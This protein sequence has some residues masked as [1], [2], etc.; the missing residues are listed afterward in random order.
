MENHDKIYEQIKNASKKTEEMD[1]PAMDKVWSRVE[2]KLDTKVLQKQNQRWKKIA[3]AASVLMLVS[4]GYQFLKPQ[5]SVKE[6]KIQNAVEVTKIT[7]AQET[8]IPVE[9]NTNSALTTTTQNPAIKKNADKILQQQIT[10]PNPVAIAEEISVADGQEVT[11]A[12]I[13]EEQQEAL[14]AKVAGSSNM[15][16]SNSNA[17]NWAKGKVYQ[18][19]S[20]NNGTYETDKN[21]NGVYYKKPAATTQKSNDP[22]YVINGE[23]AAANSG[24]N[25]KDELSKL[26]ADE[27]D[28]IEVLKEPLYII[29]GNYYSEEELFGAKPTSPYAPLDQQEI[30]TIKILQGKEAAAYGEKGKKGV[31]IITT[32]NKKPAAVKGK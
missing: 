8:K 18:A 26:S 4:M 2:D 23:A 9:A 5:E 19:K 10:S 27:I 22:L 31:V 17:N 24:K 3:V 15:A 14:K 28:S 25:A 21:D 13:K 20:V 1:F 16:S 6:N 12:A 32:K 30:E 11:R 7:E 29:N